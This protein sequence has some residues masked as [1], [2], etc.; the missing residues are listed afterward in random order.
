MS[1]DESGDRSNAADWN[2]PYEQALE[3]LHQRKASEAT[4]LAQRAVVVAE[5]AADNQE[6][7]VHT[8]DLCANACMWAKQWSAAE[9]ALMK[10]VGKESKV[11]EYWPPVNGT[12]L[13][14][15]AQALVHQG[16]AASAEPLLREALAIY[17]KYLS[18]QPPLIT[19]SLDYH[20]QRMFAYSIGPMVEEF[21]SS[22]GAPSGRYWPTHPAS[23]RVLVILA[24]A[25]GQQGKYRECVQY[26]HAAL[27]EIDQLRLL[28][29]GDEN[30]FRFW[31]GEAER[32]KLDALEQLGEADDA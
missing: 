13:A 17:L 3:K 20:E 19:D 15:L 23:I 30:A 27:M 31:Q 1:D 9:M 25:L 5:A 12:W 32:W 26:S 6:A 21:A 11:A 29:W 16:R 10:L 28:R 8:L 24:V 14:M 7:L 2:T 18:A 4:L 22:A